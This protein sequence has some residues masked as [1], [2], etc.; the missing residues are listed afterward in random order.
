M[1]STAV[2]IIH[3]D[4][5]IERVSNGETVR[6]VAKSLGISHPAISQVLHSDPAYRQAIENCFA[7]RLDESEAELSQ[8]EDQ[9]TVARARAKWQAISWRAER[10]C[11]A[12]WGKAPEQTVN[13][14]LGAGELV[15][16]N[17]AALLQKHSNVLDSV[18]DSIE[19]VDSGAM[20]EYLP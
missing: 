4:E 6:Q 7:A 10:E 12:R 3:R 18:K 5:I 15:Q 19:S 20:Q 9:L 16:G 14:N 8:A 1:P 2:A 11:P 17:L 13:I